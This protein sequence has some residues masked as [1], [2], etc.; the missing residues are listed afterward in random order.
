ME[1]VRSFTGDTN[2]AEKDTARKQF[3]E[4]EYDGMVATSAFGMGS[5][6]PTFGQSDIRIAVYIGGFISRI[7]QGARK[8]SG[9]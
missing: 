2:V 9:I 8:S 7:W 6:N 1:N 3:K 5:I 4:N